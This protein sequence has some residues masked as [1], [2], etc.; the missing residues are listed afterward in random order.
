MHIA[1]DQTK[2]PA[3]AEPY[4]ADTN[5]AVELGDSRYLLDD[6]RLAVQAT[7]CLIRPA[8]GDR[9]LV[10]ACKEGENYIVH[11]LGRTRDTDACLAVPGIERLAIRQASIELAAGERIALR[12]LGDIEVTAAAGE[13]SLTARNLFS[14][15]ADS[16]V[17]NARHYVGSVGQY[18]LEAKQLLRLHGKHT[19]ITADQDVKVDGERISVG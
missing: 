4:W 3:P 13:L 9:V 12:S 5:V 16:L 17:E 10:A 11:L 2:P 14:T 18:L 8:A 15:V 7:S 19:T 1:K 6:G